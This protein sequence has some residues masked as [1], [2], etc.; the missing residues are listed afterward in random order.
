MAYKKK[1]VNPPVFVEVKLLQEEVDLLLK[2]LEVY[3]L[4]FRN[5][6]VLELDE[7]MQD[8]INT[9]IFF[10]YEQLL[11]YK[12]SHVVSV[13]FSQMYRSNKYYINKKR[14]KLLSSKR[15]EK[16]NKNTTHENEF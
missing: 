1:N 2:S 12:H 9:M 14:Y 7:E 3:A 16:N 11:N 5:F 8:Y 13:D 10:T 15:N 4:N 6:R